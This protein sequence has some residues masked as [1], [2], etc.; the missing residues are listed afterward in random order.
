MA[1]ASTD[2]SGRVGYGAALASREFRALFAGQSV[3][4]TG[5]SVAAVA[6]TVLVYRRTGSPFLSALTF[7][8]G[9][10]PYLIGVGL[11]GLVDR[12]RPR[13]LVVTCDSLAGLI[14]CLM[15]WRGAPIALLLGLLLCLGVLASIASGSRGALVRSTVAPGAY[16]PARSLLKLASQ[17]AQI[18]GNAFGGALVVAFSPSG[19]ILV[20]AGS[21]V[22]SAAVVRLGVR[23]R[24][25]GGEPDDIGLLRDSLR[26][27]RGILGRTELRR[28]L[29][30]GWLVSM[31][32][33]APEAL[34]APYVAR[35]HGSAT[36]VGIWLVALPVGMVAGDVCGIRFLTADRQRRLVAPAAA[37][38][39]L[40]YLLFVF[41]PSIAAAIALLVVSGACG[42]YSLGLDGLVRDAAP[43]Q[44]FARTMSLNSAGLMTLQGIGFALAGAIAEVVGA[45]AAIATA[46]A[47]GLTATALLTRADLRPARGE[48]ARPE[49]RRP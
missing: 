18:A 42:L 26:G 3:S 40:P 28:L 13:R 25:H 30:L 41:R 49:P 16:V 35:H 47:L 17:S 9:F 38:G 20:N 27:A 19:A 2:R 39:F 14:A 43:E 22:F 33:V 31:F 5:T 37:A 29:L 4:T 12:V 36:L 24:P 7:S 6:L 44:L 32:S 46:G 1:T 8:L 23:D 10:L 34:A 45:P 21:F 48:L 11:S 15:A